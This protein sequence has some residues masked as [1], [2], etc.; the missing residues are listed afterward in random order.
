VFAFTGISFVA[1]SIAVIF[2]DQVDNF[3]VKEEELDP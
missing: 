3:Y 1:A 2:I